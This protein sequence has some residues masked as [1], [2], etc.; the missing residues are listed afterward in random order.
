MSLALNKVESFSTGINDLRSS[1]SLSMNLY[2]VPLIL[3]SYLGMY[4]VSLTN[5]FE[6]ID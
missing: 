5:A 3:Y 1:N 4:P 6:N 2:T